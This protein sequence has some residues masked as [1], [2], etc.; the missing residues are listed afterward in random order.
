[1]LLVVSL[2]AILIQLITFA[3]VF[4]FTPIYALAL[5]ATKLDMGLLTLI[6]TLPTA[7]AAWV[8]PRHVARWL[9]EKNVIIVGFILCGVFTMIIPL[10]S[11]LG[12]LMLTQFIAGFGRGLAAPILMSL[13][14]KFIDSGQRATAMGFYQAIYG[15]GMFLGPLFMGAIGDLL[16]L[17]EGF[18]IV[19]GIGCFAA[20]LTYYL[21]RLKSIAMS[22]ILV[23]AQ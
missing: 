19:G 6:S 16:T 4:G 23:K 17:K 20:V 5:G 14:I 11:S 2:L 7:I 9:G 3:T 15:F 8:G 1:M 21:F 12:F 13:S 22:G 18:V 10:S